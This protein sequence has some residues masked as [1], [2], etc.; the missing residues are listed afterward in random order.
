ML[1]RPFFKRSLQLM[2]RKRKAW[3]NRHLRA[4]TKEKPE[5]MALTDVRTQVLPRELKVQRATEDQDKQKKAR[6]SGLPSWDGRPGQLQPRGLEKAAGGVCASV[7]V[8]LNVR[9][10]N[11]EKHTRK[12]GMRWPA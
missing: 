3:R 9:K 8:V 1:T 4:V 5:Q 7:S 2:L 10:Q 11:E 6:A 12:R